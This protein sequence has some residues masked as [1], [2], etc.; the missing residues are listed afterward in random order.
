MPARYHFFGL[1]LSVFRLGSLS[2][3]RTNGHGLYLV[4]VLARPDAGG[5]LTT[6]WL[7][8]IRLPC[9]ECILPSPVYIAMQ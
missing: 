3:L 5:S 7:S 1:A 2:G 6:F 4:Y 8:E 9:V